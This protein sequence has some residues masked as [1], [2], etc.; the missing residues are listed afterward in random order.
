MR[1]HYPRISIVTPSFNQGQFLEQT[2]LSVLGQ[3]YPNLEY[4]I[5]DGGSSDNSVEIIKKYENQIKFWV[6][7]KDNGQ[8]QA[9]NKGF[10]IASGDILGWLNSDDMYFP[11]IFNKLIEQIDIEKTGI[12]YGECIHF[13]LENEILKS[14]G[15][16]VTKN[17]RN[18]DLTINDFIIQPSSF[19]TS[20]TW[21]KVG[22]LNENMHYAF[23]WEWFIRALQLGVTF[24]PINSPLSIYRIH[25]AHKSGTGGSMRQ[26]EISEIY[27][28]YNPK[29]KGLY[30]SLCKE[31]LIYKSS[32]IRLINHILHQLMLPPSF[33]IIL[34]FLKYYRYYPYS[35]RDINLV[36]SML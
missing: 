27:N 12:Y 6:S 23:D 32:L 14:T 20:M 22:N 11:G 5:I 28:E 24:N 10:K 9:I 30:N 25:E 8:C 18:G 1:H 36:S 26:Q 31:K 17:F 34:K 33:G 3:N 16:H 29:I 4:I 19:W 15:S 13:K 21:M 2:I 35:I 7:E